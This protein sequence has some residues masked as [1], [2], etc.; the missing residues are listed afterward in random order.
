[1]EE[2][3][4]M[5]CPQC[6]KRKKRREA[7]QPGKV[8]A[9]QAEEEGERVLRHTVQPLNKVWLKIG[10]EK[11]DTHEGATVK[12]LLDSRATRMFADKKFVERNGFKLERL[13][14][15]VRIKNVDG[16][17]NSGGLVS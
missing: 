12:A 13:D 9:Q 6:M 3:R 10:I 11:V 8:K 16:M 4:S 15:P 2:I 1:M 5:K 17:G 7:V 14:R